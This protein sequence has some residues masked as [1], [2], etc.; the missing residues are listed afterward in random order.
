MGVLNVEPFI[1]NFIYNRETANYL[2]KRFTF[3]KDKGSILHKFWSWF[4]SY[5]FDL[6][7]HVST[8]MQLSAEDFWQSPKTSANE[9][10]LSGPSSIPNCLPSCEKI[11]IVRMMETFKNS[12]LLLLSAACLTLGCLRSLRNFWKIHW[13]ST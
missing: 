11:I 13:L 6:F 8:I 1:V 2:R 5:L 9:C 4:V 3:L 7:A 12:C 10:V